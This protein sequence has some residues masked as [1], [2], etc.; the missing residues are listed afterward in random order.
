[1]RTTKTIFSY[2]LA[3]GYNS[4]KF[5]SLELLEE[6]IF[7]THSFQTD[8]RFSEAHSDGKILKRDNS[9]GISTIIIDNYLEM[10]IH[11]IKETIDTH[12][13]KIL[14]LL[15]PY[16]TTE[17][18]RKDILEELEKE[19]HFIYNVKITLEKIHKINCED[20]TIVT[21]TLDRLVSER[22]IKKVQNAINDYAQQD[23]PLPSFLKS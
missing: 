4:P 16:A 19:I 15:T 9:D 20:L 7:I 13:Y 1:M 12:T 2:E 6:H 23:S 11:L 18:S 3:N 22:V 5:D 17:Q 14:V 10:E 8:A 21:I